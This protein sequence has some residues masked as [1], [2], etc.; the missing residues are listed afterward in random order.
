MELAMPHFIIEILEGLIDSF[1]LLLGVVFF[2]FIPTAILSI[3]AWMN[4]Q[5]YSLLYSWDFGF[6][7]YGSIF[8]M[9]FYVI[10]G[11]S[12]VSFAN[13]MI[14]LQGISLFALFLIYARSF[15]LGRFFENG[16]TASISCIAILFGAVFL[17]RLF[18]PLFPD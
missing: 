4:L 2:F 7:L 11:D 6:P 18:I 17:L 12:K 16:K 13:T 1:G 3:P 5:K 8:W 10:F 14:E 15:L 9:V